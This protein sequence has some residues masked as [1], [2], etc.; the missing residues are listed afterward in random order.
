MIRI[1]VR[2]ILGSNNLNKIN[3]NRVNFDGIEQYYTGNWLIGKTFVFT[4]GYKHF[5]I[6]SIKI[7][8]ELH[9]GAESFYDIVT[10]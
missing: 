8:H 6:A 7:D 1:L 4:K 10:T 3:T 2:M 5:V 9:F